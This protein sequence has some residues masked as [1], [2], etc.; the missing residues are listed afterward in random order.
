MLPLPS[1]WVKIAAAT[2]GYGDD[3]GPRGYLET[4]EIWFSERVRDGQPPREWMYSPDMRHRVPIP[5]QRDQAYGPI[6]IRTVGNARWLV[7]VFDLRPPPDT[8]VLLVRVWDRR[9]TRIF[10]LVP[11]T[12]PL[13]DV[14]DLT[15]IDSTLYMTQKSPDNDNEMSLIAYDLDRSTHRVVIRN[16][17][18]S[19]WAADR[20]HIVAAQDTPDHRRPGKVRYYDRDGNPD[21]TISPF[22]IDPDTTGMRL[23]DDGYLYTT[24]NLVAEHPRAYRIDPKSGAATIIAQSVDDIPGRGAEV[25]DVT[26]TRIVYFRDAIMHIHDTRTGITVQGTRRTE[27]GSTGMTTEQ[28]ENGKALWFD[29]TLSHTVLLDELPMPTHC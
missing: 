12:K 6:G 27:Q 21:P 7:Y 18:G 25:L 15:L 5:Y 28:V 29:G 9:R 1:S 20:T 16:V 2:P 3:R 10:V 4:G 24:T 23:F 11:E 8:S 13:N 26:G 14:A 19:V 17:F 22:D